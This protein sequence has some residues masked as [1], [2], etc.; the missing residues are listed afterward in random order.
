MT[1][2]SNIINFPAKSSPSKQQVDT[3]ASPVEPQALTAS[4]VVYPAAA[5][6]A[7]VAELTP[8][9]KRA[10]RLVATLTGMPHL[11][12]KRKTKGGHS[13]VGSGTLT[14]AGK[15]F[16]HADA[17]ILGTAAAIA[18]VTSVILYSEGLPPEG[19]TLEARNW[20]KQHEL[21]LLEP[22][23]MLVFKHFRT[24]YAVTKYSIKWDRET[25]ER[26]QD[27]FWAP[28]FEL[29]PPEL[30]VLTSLSRPVY[31]DNGWPMSAKAIAK[32]AVSERFWGTLKTSMAAMGEE[33]A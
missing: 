21:E 6:R 18:G 1:S 13:S 30:R 15:E 16:T 25:V 5:P 10:K 19:L 11:G 27:E 7:S 23:L 31:S 2:T 29:L 32:K 20:G 12:A 24:G 9:K 4:A 17:A 22:S 33:I 26:W 28:A 8:A 3:G 14:I